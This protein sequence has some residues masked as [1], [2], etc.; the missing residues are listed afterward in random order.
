[1]SQNADVSSRIYLTDTIDFQY[2]FPLTDRSF[3]HQKYVVEGLSRRQIAALTASS[4]ATVTRY[5]HL[6]NIATACPEHRSW[7]HPGQLPYGT[8]IRNGRVVPNKAE[9][10][11]IRRM[12]ELRSCGLTYR[13]IAA[14]L[15]ATG[16]PTKTG[17]PSWAAT[18]IMKLVSRHR[19]G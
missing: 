5:L 10:K 3:L 17:R 11:V 16:I 4:R 6:H 14:K 7:Q 9:L 18:T 2:A 1:M 8:R 13:Q 19:I 15:E 12:C